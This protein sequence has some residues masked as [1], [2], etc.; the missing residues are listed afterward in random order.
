MVNKSL[1]GGCGGRWIVGV[2]RLSNGG[3]WVLGGCGGVI[4]AGGERS[5][6]HHIK[7]EMSNC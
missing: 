2:E 6:Q 5:N 4:K 3:Q 1:G 7:I